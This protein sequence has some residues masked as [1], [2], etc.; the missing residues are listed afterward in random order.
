MYVNSMHLRSGVW[1]GAVKL[2]KGKAASQPAIQI[3]DDWLYV[4]YRG[5]DDNKLYWQRLPYLPKER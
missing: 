1:T 5:T 3:F 4:I 2:T